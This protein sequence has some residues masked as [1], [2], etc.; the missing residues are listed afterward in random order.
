MSASICVDVV[1]FVLMVFVV[2][3]EP[4][5]KHSWALYITKRAFE[6]NLFFPNEIRLLRRSGRVWHHAITVAYGFLQRQ[7]VL[8]NG[9]QL[10]KWPLPPPSALLAEVHRG[11]VVPL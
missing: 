2:H 1:V 11:H 10:P 8:T 3:R 5:L 4:F 7:L 9:L 6:V